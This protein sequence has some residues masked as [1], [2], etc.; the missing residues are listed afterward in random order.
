MINTSTLVTIDD[1]P[2][3]DLEPYMNSSDISSCKD[4]A[5]SFHKYGICI[6]KDPRVNMEDNNEYIDLMEKYFDTVSGPY[7]QDKTLKEA[8]PEYHYLVGATPENQEKARK[9]EKKIRTLTEE[10]LPM[11]PVDPVYDAKWRYSWKIGERP[12]A[13]MDNFPQVIPADNFEAWE[14]KMDKWGNKL[15]DAVYTVAEMVALGLGLEKDKFSSCLKGGAHLL[16][17]TGSDLAKNG[18]G[19]IFAGFHYDIS[20]LTIHGKSR[21]PGLFVWLRNN[22]K[23]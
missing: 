9:H 17:P 16:A 7:Y 19:S 23:L 1:I 21:Y 6:I 11:S 3:I 2:V 8:K 14:E 15:H 18:Q 20:F 10:N 22:Q 4:V 12:D 5:E 13:A